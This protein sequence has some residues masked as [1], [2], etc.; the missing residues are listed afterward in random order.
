[1]GNLGEGPVCISVLP[2]TRKHLRLNTIKSHS[3]NLQLFS[4]YWRS[5]IDEMK[6]RA[7]HWDTVK[8]GEIARSSSCFHDFK[9]F[10]LTV[11]IPCMCFCLH[12]KNFLQKME[13]IFMCVCC[14]ELAF[15]PVTTLCSHNVCKVCSVHLSGYIWNNRYLKSLSSHLWMNFYHLPSTDL[16]PAVV[17]SQGVHL[18]RLP[19]RL[20]QG[21]RHDPKQDAPDAAWPVLSRLQQGP[22]RSKSHL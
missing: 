1:M 6:S 19:S 11:L 15:Q 7:V 21:L 20:G 4:L 12:V 5:L 18:P 10:S 13:Q 2:D 22:M 16:S 14:Q 9:L 17:S 3:A 8:C